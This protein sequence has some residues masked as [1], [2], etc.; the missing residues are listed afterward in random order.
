MRPIQALCLAAF[1]CLF[2]FTL[3]SCS[4]GEPLTQ[5]LPT[6]T[7]STASTPTAAVTPSITLQTPSAIASPT[8]EPEA[9]INVTRKDYDDAIAKWRAADVREY[10]MVADYQSGNAEMGGD[11]KLRVRDGKIVEIYRGD[12]RVIIDDSSIPNPEANPSNLRFLTVEAQ[13]EAIRKLFED[14]SSRGIV[15]GG[16][17]YEAQYRIKFNDGLGYPEMYSIYPV[18]ITDNERMTGIKS[19][20]VI[21]QGPNAKMTVI[22]IPLRP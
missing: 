18:Q 14:P 10:E 5:T 17:R 7:L 20:R 2:L 1:C 12:V 15:I 9:E 6:S 11:W 8:V 16:K 13:F 19:L 4:T 22:P 21:E 3:A